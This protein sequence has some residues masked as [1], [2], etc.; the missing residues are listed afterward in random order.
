MQIARFDIYRAKIQF[1]KSVDP[2][3]CI[4]L[5][6]PTQDP[7]APPGTLVVLV[8]PLS[9]QMDLY[10]PSRHFLLDDVDVDFAAT[11]L[12]RKSYV[13]ATAPAHVPVALL[14]KKY[15]ALAGDL[16]VRF[17]FWLPGVSSSE[18]GPST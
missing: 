5:R 15:G 17:L 4:V 9:S 2:R 1:G 10:D 11:G 8:A 6:E 18:A 12:R 3:P 16:L 14:E 13:I 7:D